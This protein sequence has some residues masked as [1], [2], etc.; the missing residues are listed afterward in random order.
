LPLGFKQRLALACAIMHEP[1]I[2]F[3]DEPTSGVDP[4]T[5]REFWTHI[6]GLVEKGVTVMVTTHYMEEAEYCDHIGLVYRGKLIAAGTPDELKQSVVT[7]RKPEPTMEDAFIDLVQKHD[8]HL[9]QSNQTATTTEQST[10]SIENKKPSNR[11]LIVNDSLR[12]WVALCKKEFHQIIRDPSSILIAFVLPLIMLFLY[13]Y[14]LN[15]DS[16]EIH[17][18]LVMNDKSPAARHLAQTLSKSPYITALP[19]ENETVGRNALIAGNIRGFVTIMPNFTQQL[20]RENSIAPMQITTDG[21]EP[22]TANFVAGYA[23]GA[24]QTWQQQQSIEKGKIIY[25][26][27]S[28]E[29]RNWFN[30]AVI[31]RYFLVPGSIVIIM[32]VI[33]ALLTSLVVAREWE[34]GTMEALLSTP[35]TRKELL[36]SKLI[37][38]YLLGMGAMTICLLF[39]VII[40]GTP[41]RGSV[42]LL[43]VSTSLFLGSTLG[44]GLLLSTLLR[45]QFNA[46]QAALNIAFLPAVMFSGFVYEISSMPH[47][48]QA[49]T[50]IFP[51]RY[52]VAI[53]QSLFLAGNIPILLFK[54]GLFLLCSAVVFL[55]LSGKFTKRTLD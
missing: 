34:R 16:A 1:A 22:N 54:D 35:I 13:G 41:F 33:G 51:A 8:Q 48:V 27:I 36:L 37:P 29:P 15:L 46:A 5:R 43:F 12:R 24:W 26:P 28:I 23:T 4:I 39:A 45:N 2:L 32:T 18:G 11:F 44:V 42:F 53:L 30:P 17:I 55:G 50:Y 10:I 38:Y 21:A 14:G 6:N 52:F 40:L 31:S 49:V 20:Y 25:N 19:Q 47:I 9:E 7:M 3:L